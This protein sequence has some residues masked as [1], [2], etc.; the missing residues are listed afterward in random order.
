MMDS[1]VIADGEQFKVRKSVVSPV[2]VSVVY[3]FSCEQI[4]A[5]IFS[6]DNA[7]LKLVGISDSDGHIAIASHKA[8]NVLDFSTAGHRAK[9]WPTAACPAGFDVK[10]FPASFAYNLNWHNDAPIL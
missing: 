6:H 4:A 5:K 10:S 9:S 2:T 7:M 8:A 3:V 1:G